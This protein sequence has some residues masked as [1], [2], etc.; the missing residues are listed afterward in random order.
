MDLSPISC[1]VLAGGR[2]TRMGSDKRFL[3]MRGKTWLANAV[4][5]LQSLQVSDQPVL[6]SGDVEGFR[7]VPDLE[8]G[9]GPL[10]GLYSVMKFLWNEDPRERWLLAIPVDMPYL[11]RS[12]LDPL[13]VAARTVDGSVMAFAEHELPIILLVNPRT[14]EQVGQI[15]E[16]EPRWRSFR[17]LHQ[18]VK[19]HWLNEVEAGVGKEEFSNINSFC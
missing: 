9:Q 16:G 1:V 7:C 2:S 17:Q 10:M 8:P 11:S 12:A 3:L 5:L 19:T 14:I 4:D 15:L 13:V 6:V 18:V